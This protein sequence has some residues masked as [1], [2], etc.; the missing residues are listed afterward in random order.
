MLDKFPQTYGLGALVNPVV[1]SRE[2]SDIGRATVGQSG[3]DVFGKPFLKMK[4]VDD[5]IRL[6]SNISVY[7]N[8]F[9]PKG[10]K[11]LPKG[12][13]VLL[14][15]KKAVSEANYLEDASGQRWIP[16]GWGATDTNAQETTAVPENGADEDWKK[17]KSLVT[18]DIVY[19]DAKRIRAVALV[20]DCRDVGASAVEPELV[21]SAV[22]RKA[23]APPV[24]WANLAFSHAGKICVYDRTDYK[25][26][27]GSMTEEDR[28]SRSLR[29]M[30]DD[31][32]TV[33]PLVGAIAGLPLDASRGVLDKLTK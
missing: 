30:A 9:I 15:V 24:K 20:N 17:L 28:A 11:V 14:K 16:L 3:Y 21:A 29:H 27:I 26:I 22:G 23:V 25:N 31:K 12:H 18:Y 19:K 32:T 7:T 13:S 33:D 10:S 4:A 1:D 6:S 8:E 2:V 5:D